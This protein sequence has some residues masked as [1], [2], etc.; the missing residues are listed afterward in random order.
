[1]TEAAPGRGD[2]ETHDAAADPKSADVHAPEQAGETAEPSPNGSVKA[3]AV[4]NG[5]PADESEGS[6][7]E[8]DSD[9][10]EGNGDEAED[11]DDDSDESDSDSEDDEPK[12]KYAKLTSHLGPVYRNGDMTSAFLVAGDK[13]I[14]G[15]HDGNIHV[16]QLP[17]FHSLRNYHAHSASVTSVSI[18]PYPPP[19][20][21][22]KP[23]AAAR[24]LS[25]SHSSPL[26]PGSAV[27]EPRSS[28][29]AA[30][31]KPREAPVVPNI[32][33][34]SIYIAT[35]SL[36]GNVCVQSLI[37]VA[38][39]SL[40]NYARPVQ[41][42]ALS[43]EYKHDRMYLSGGLAGQLILTVEAP[44]GRST[45]TTTGASAQAAGWL[46]SMVGATT[47]KDT[48]LHS[49]EGI[50]NAIRWSISG[51]YVVWFNEHG[52]KIMR[53]KLHLESADAED[54]WKRIGH[55]DRPDTEE[56]STMASV[57][58]ARAEWI[59]EQAVE[60]EENDH[61]SQQSQQVAPSPAA[62]KLKQ[63]QRKSNKVIE[64][65]IV[66]WGNMVWIVHVHPGSVGVGKNVGERSAGRAE[67]VKRLR[68]DCIISGIS[69]YTQNLLLVLAYCS[70][71]KDD[72]DDDEGKAASGHKH[73]SSTTSAGS[74]PSGGL[75][76]KL[77]NLPPEL[78]LVDLTSQ[79]LVDLT[80][81][82]ISR[83]ERLTAGDY[84]LGMLPAQNVA[85]VASSR[86]ALEALAGFGTDM[87]NVALNPKSLLFSSG[88]SIRSK[89]SKDGASGSKIPSTAGSIAANQRSGRG[90][91]E[92][93]LTKPGVKI[94][95]H[96]PYDCI[97]ATKRDLGDHLTWLL[98]RRQYQAAWE[99]VD[100]HPEIASSSST[101]P[102]H[103]QSSASP[104]RRQ[105]A[106]DDFYD[107]TSSVME[108][109]RTYYSSAEKEKRRIGELWV[110]QL[111]EAG[112]WTQAGQ[113]CGKVLGSP[114]RWQHWVQTFADADKFDEIVNYMPTERTRPP[115][116]GKTYE[117][118]L[119]HYLA[120]SK[121]RFQNLLERWPTDLF[122]ASAISAS[123]Q[124]QLDYRD[125]REDS[126][127][128]GEVGRDWHIVMESLAKLHEAS[129]RKREALKCY[130]KL[131]FGD[132]AMR[133]I[134]EGHL[135]E[136]IA[137]DIPSF[138]GL[139]VPP[140]GL[141]K[142]TPAEL[143]Q[144][145]AEATTLLVDEAQHGL[146]KPGVVINQLQAKKLHLYTFFY[147]RGLWR[148]EGIHEHGGESRARLVSDSQSLV[149]NFA[150]LAV[151]LFAVYDQ[152]LL[153]DFLRTSTAYAFE[154]AAQE[155]EQ[156]NYIPELV[157]L[158]SKTGQMK[159]AL[160]L[161]IDRLGDVSRAIAFAKEQNDPD[162]WE[163][164]LNY[165]MDKPRFIRGLL[166]EVGT[167][168]D[169]I[170]LV[171]RIPEGLE[172]EGL[173]EGLKHIM[174]EHEIQYSISSGV[175]RVLRSE[176]AAAQ[177]LLRNGQRKG[178]KFEVA[179]HDADHIDVETKDVPTPAPKQIAN[180]GQAR[181]DDEKADAGDAGAQA[182]ANGTANQPTQRSAAKKWQPGHCAQCSE[183]FTEW[184][185]ETLV[186]FACGHVFHL[187]HL[188]Q[189]LHPDEPIDD[190]LLLGGGAADDRS[191]QRGNL[192]GAKVTHA[193]LLRDHIMGGCPVCSKNKQD[194]SS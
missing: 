72:A 38:D 163:D 47:G 97:L 30:S 120:T 189:H 115:I 156:Y 95:I 40:R 25:Q 33:S 162:L 69:L 126:V 29:A 149:D 77:N 42:V 173:R 85:A 36:D 52:F 51:K 1:M 101:S 160:Y 80:V 174:K 158:Y 164:L 94:F 107:E 64:R 161:I 166:E 70:P 76:R 26:R 82:S 50:I 122:D 125:V 21:V 66:G 22:L 46:G 31:R 84:H 150:D 41:A 194:L 4:N 100:E 86:G 186:G 9:E 37:D 190:D 102:L 103:D 87:L 179:V 127:E 113:V 65:L 89:D 131:Q 16:M 34:N 6:G 18:S 45:A 93:N 169:P 112:N 165:S 124:D 53:T 121:P 157:Y 96:S 171:R 88:A 172:V 7:E 14:I 61:E 110:Q 81:L 10:A 49:G 11:D 99:L 175:A 79:E 123:L 139:R 55:G 181:K 48:V 28:S 56:W 59:D 155:C 2:K 57:W 143:E 142:M 129:G 135:A 187:A 111:I 32:P 106:T 15:T 71:D 98:E 35:S 5:G 145:T 63:Q 43:P 60:W 3:S 117:H 108:G 119:K 134:K 19:L 105:S 74:A 146:V 78:R 168:I 182:Q 83:F 91:V 141:K 13:M 62:E 116:P 183:P 8:D 180:V 12:L 148:G 133:L 193:R 185:M 27:S 153:M 140:D 54:A 67:F 118:V 17:I 192:I 130:I 23:D 167:A 68:M 104:D 152:S 191:F 138:I 154:K 114:D 176:V 109:M 92:P 73:T 177:I 178:I 147:L 20:P 137:D 90:P 188:L 39:V 132:A 75:R 159:R 44:R 58:K 151:H 24:I 128:D 170:T 184:E 144:A 136:A